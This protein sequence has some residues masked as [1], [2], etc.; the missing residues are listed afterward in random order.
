MTDDH[1]KNHEFSQNNR[2]KTI[3]SADIDRDRICKNNENFCRKTNYPNHSNI[4]NM[5]FILAVKVSVESYDASQ[6]TQYREYDQMSCIFDF[7]RSL[8]KL[9]MTFISAVKASVESYDASQ[10]T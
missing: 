1:R 10:I 3:L 9:D 4:E 6:V 8:P 7:S 2:K 5:T